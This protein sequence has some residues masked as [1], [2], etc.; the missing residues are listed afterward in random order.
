MEGLSWGSGVKGGGGKG[1][2]RV[3][4]G[5]KGEGGKGIAGGARTGG[6]VQKRGFW[7]GRKGPGVLGEHKGCLGGP[8]GLV[9][10]G[11]DAGGAFQGC[12]GEQG[13]A[14]GAGGRGMTL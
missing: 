1:R 13:G 12:L 3:E 2:G 14:G 8:R 9:E 4:G 11:E 5:S 6:R 7:R 10:R